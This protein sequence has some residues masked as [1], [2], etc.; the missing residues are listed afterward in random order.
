M[1]LFRTIILVILIAMSLAAG[2]A[3]V[4]QMPQE[5]QFFAQAGLSVPLLMGLGAL[6]IVGGALS[7]FPKF[8]IPG[9]L[10]MGAGFLVSAIII[11][12]TGNL[13]FAAMSL[14][15]VFFAGFIAFGR[16]A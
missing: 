11:L 3:K 2:A 7:A 9:A 4:F 13:G 10:L 12:I 6:Q 1:K 16:G 15:P 8:R 5:V 14:L